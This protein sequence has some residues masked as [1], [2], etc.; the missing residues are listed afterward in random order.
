VIAIFILQASVLSLND[1]PINA[2]IIIIII[3]IILPTTM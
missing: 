3:I 1:F 2:I